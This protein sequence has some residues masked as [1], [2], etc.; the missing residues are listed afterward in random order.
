MTKM[1]N[2]ILL[3]ALIAVFSPA[4]VALEINAAFAD[5]ADTFKEMQDTIKNERKTL[6]AETMELSD[7]ESKKFWPLYEKYRAEIGKANEKTLKIITDYAA[8]Y[9]NLSNKQARALL[10]EWLKIQQRVLDVRKDYLPKFRRTLPDTKVTRFYQVENKL[11][12]IMNFD[13]ARKI[14]LMETP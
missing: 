10:D 8:Q 2:I 12:A 11:D 1:L 4:V 6:V 13:L 7:K 3:S 9:P 5:L 14:P